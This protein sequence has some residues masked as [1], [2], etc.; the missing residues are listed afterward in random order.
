MIKRTL[1]AVAGLL[2][3][4]CAG[5]CKQGLGDRCQIDSDC[6][7]QLYCELAGNSIAMGGSCRSRAGTLDMSAPAV[8]QSQGPD[9]S[10][11]DLQSVA[12]L[13]VSDGGDGT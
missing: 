10:M 3:L 12:D 4:L 6:E 8:D 13:P 11:P 5:G 1:P 9:L 2:W 7:D